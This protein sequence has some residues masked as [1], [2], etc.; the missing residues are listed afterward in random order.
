MET[1]PKI[2]FAGLTHLGINSAIAAAEKG[3][4]VIGFHDSSDLISDL[5][6]GKS[7]ITEP[8]LIEKLNSNKARIKFVENPDN[9][10]NENVPK[11]VVNLPNL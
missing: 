3:F 11:N 1:K 4:Q 5:A 9:N 8:Q 2:G 6:N 10:D 7:P